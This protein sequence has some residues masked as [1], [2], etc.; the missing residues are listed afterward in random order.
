MPADT[1]ALTRAF[2]ERHGRPATLIAEAP[3]RVNLIGEHTDYNDGFVLP[4]AIDRTTAVAAAP[5]DD[6]RV[7]VHAVDFD[8][9][10][11]FSLSAAKR[12]PMGGWRNYVRG[13]LWALLDHQ[14]P[15]RG[16]DLS[17]SSDVPAGA[18]LSSSA[19]LELAVAGALCAAAS[20]ALPPRELALLCQR[21][22]H[23]YAGVQ[24]GIMDQFA[25]A[26]GEAGRALFLDCRSLDVEHIPI[27]EDIAIVVIDSRVPRDLAATPYNRRHGECTEAASALG[28]ASLRDADATD[29]PKLPNKLQGRARHVITENARVLAAVAALRTGDTAALGRLLA[30]SHASL[31]DDFEVSTPEIDALVELAS[32]APGVIGARLTGG[33]FGGGTVNL[34]EAGQTQAPID[35]VVSAYKQRTG[36][37]AE[38]HV[39]RAVGGMRVRDV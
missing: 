19:A 26:L 32:D 21:A 18:G 15:L 17:I 23:M 30:E 5:R 20:V 39:C 36:L 25:S 38:A 3:G 12:H 10:D 33:G 2:A 24:C 37:D 11:D 35:A 7:R 22:E 13:V 31:R 14:V 1:D 27:P 8:Q 4:A 34:V 28:V 16:V 6:T 9:C 29:I